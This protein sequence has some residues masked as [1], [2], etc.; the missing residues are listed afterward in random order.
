MSTVSAKL[1]VIRGDLEDWAVSEYV[2]WLCLGEAKPALREISQL[3][4]LAATE[5][6]PR[7]TDET[8]AIVQFEVLDA[9]WDFGLELDVILEHPLF[10]TPAADLYGPVRYTAAYVHPPGAYSTEEVINGF[11]RGDLEIRP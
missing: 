9:A 1:E 5:N 10:T 8:L 6:Q 11:D 4:V 3:A 7:R 2:M